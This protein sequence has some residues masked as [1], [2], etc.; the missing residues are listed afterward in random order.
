MKSHFLSALSGSSDWFIGLRTRRGCFCILSGTVLTF[1]IWLYILV[2]SADTLE[3]Y[4]LNNGTRTA[5]VLMKKGIAW[6]TDKH[7]KF[8]NPGGNDNLTVAFQG[9]LLINVS[10]IYCFFLLNR[11]LPYDLRLFRWWTTRSLKRKISIT[12][13]RGMYPQLCK[14]NS[15]G[16][17]QDCNFVL[18][19]KLCI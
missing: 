2:V 4:Y 10:R 12:Y 5:V 6:W 13:Y 11:L 18:P 15:L 8:R 16:K 14:N 3:L 1:F 7:V 19:Q 17:N 9:Q